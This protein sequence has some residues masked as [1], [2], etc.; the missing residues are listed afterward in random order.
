M[1]QFYKGIEATFLDNA[2]FKLPYELMGAVI[3]R[4]DK[5]IDD[6]IGQYQG[7]L[8][9][10]KADVLE[11]DSPEL[12]ATIQKYQNRI[13]EAIQGITKDPM[14][15][16]KYTPQLSTLG[17]EI[18]TIWGSTGKVGTMEANKK[19]V[20]A[21]YDTLEKLHEKDP[22]KYDADYITAE[23]RRILEKYK[24]VEWNEERGKAMGAPD[25]ADSYHALDFDESFLTHLKA[26]KISRTQETAGGPWVYK[27]EGSSEKLDPSTIMNTYMLQINADPT[28]QAALERRNLI[29][30]PGYESVGLNEVYIKQPITDANGNVVY[31]DGKVQ[32]R[33]VL[34]PNNYWA[35][36]MGA[37]GE[38][39]KV[40]N[41]E[42]KN[43]Q[44]ENSVY[45]RE[46]TWQRE[47]EAAKKESFT[48]ETQG[49]E[50]IVA[51][52]A[53]LNSLGTTY[54]RARAQLS[55]TVNTGVGIVEGLGLSQSLKEKVT[56]DIKN[57][58]F[59]SLRAATKDRGGISGTIDQL[60]TSYKRANSEKRLSEASMRAF[61]QSLPANLQK[62]MLDNHWNS[63]PALVKEY[64]NYTSKAKGENK[65]FELNP[66]SQVTS[67]NNMD[68]NKSTKDSFGKVIT[69]NIDDIRFRVAGL[70]AD[71][72]IWE[73]ADGTKIAFTTNR[74]LNGKPGVVG[75]TKTSSGKAVT[76]V[77]SD[78][79]EHSLKELQDLG[80]AGKNVAK[81]GAKSTY[82]FYDN[83]KKIGVEVDE[84]TLGVV[85]GLDNKGRKNLGVHLKIGANT[86]K[87]NIGEDQITNPQVRDWFSKNDSTMYA[88]WKDDQTNWKMIDIDQKDEAGNVYRMNRGKATINGLEVTA[89]ADIKIVKRI[90]MGL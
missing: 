28:A 61:T 31:K 41:S 55:S 30:T 1:G 60:E 43:T 36:K 78:T 70:Q 65:F 73:K 88:N 34:N 76:Y 50:A 8:D 37:A 15:Y 29:G 64:E 17:R 82:H 85:S 16:Q 33:E 48:A 80:V 13:D 69:E 79:E 11:Q 72:T 27:H 32:T 4:K 42:I 59:A 81:A 7:Q 26:Q 84:N 68:M 18:T 47:D 38:T 6:T 51:R 9:K 2:M 75:K 87:A 21:E 52:D 12:Q 40:N 3:D 77:Y 46:A 25:I 45:T 53:N 35:K 62:R 14:N 56:N 58:N 22:K 24:G 44:S 63:D 67:L 20:L 83:G 10:L 89:P 86:I 19:R 66:V 39:F 57:G 5:A 49:E 90:A 74:A 71:K 54:T 23:K